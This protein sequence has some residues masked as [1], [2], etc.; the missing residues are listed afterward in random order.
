[1]IE[2]IAWMCTRCGYKTTTN[3]NEGRRNTKPICPACHDGASTGFNTNKPEANE[4]PTY[5]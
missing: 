2:I 3:P 1:M 5:R 4:I